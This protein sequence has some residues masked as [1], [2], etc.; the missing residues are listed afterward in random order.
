[1]TDICMKCGKPLTY[2][3][4]GAH[5]RFINRGST[6]F[7]CKRCLAERLGISTEFIDDKIEHFKRQ[8][9]TLFH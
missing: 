5:K 8:G 2:N 6:S 4:I 1:M 9:C 7:L 3:E